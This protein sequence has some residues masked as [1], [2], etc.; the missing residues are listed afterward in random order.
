MVPNTGMLL[1][2]LFNVVAAD[3]LV[4]T[5]ELAVIGDVPP[6][7]IAAVLLNVTVP[8]LVVIPATLSTVPTTNAPALVKLKPLLLPVTWAAIVPTT[9]DCVKVT[10]PVLCTAKLDSVIVSVAFCVTVP[11]VINDKVEA[12][13]GAIA[14]D[15]VMLPLFA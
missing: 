14:A 10:A 15:T 13:D 7:V 1:V 4:T 11:P 3:V 9:F 8:L 6:C 2:A 5:K 12:L